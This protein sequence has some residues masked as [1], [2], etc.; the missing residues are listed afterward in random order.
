LTPA[1]L[2]L[3]LFLLLGQ[4]LSAIRQAAYRKAEHVAPML[5]EISHSFR[6]CHTPSETES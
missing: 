5:R 3:A 2:A 4:R 6:G 1:F